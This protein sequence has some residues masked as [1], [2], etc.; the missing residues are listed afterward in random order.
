MKQTFLALMALS[1]IG[2]PA[3]AQNAVSG[4][5]VNLQMQQRLE[6]ANSYEQSVPVNML[7]EGLAKE[8]FT[9]SNFKANPELVNRV[10]AAYDMNS[11]RE[12]STGLLAYHFT[13]D[14]I[15]AM[16]DFY[17]SPIGQ[18]IYTKMPGYLADLAP[19]LQS[20]TKKAIGKTM[21]NSLQ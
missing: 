2:L 8:F 13:M 17:S 21:Q 1:F 20:E 6:A 12:K 9:Q 10:L 19:V 5:N 3:Y 4:K 11:L 18:S 14:E 7:V 16:R 15:I